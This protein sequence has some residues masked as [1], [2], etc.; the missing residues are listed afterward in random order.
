MHKNKASSKF[1]LGHPTKNTQNRLP[2][3]KK[4]DQKVSQRTTL[5]RSEKN[6]A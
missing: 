1:I 3:Y 5:G 2:N 6:R 4:D